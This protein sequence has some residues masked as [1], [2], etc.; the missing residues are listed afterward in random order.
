M[1]KQ[2]ADPAPGARF[3]HVYDQRGEPT[4]DSER[5]RHRVGATIDSR[6][7]VLDRKFKQ[8]IE[9]KIGISAPYTKSWP[10]FVK[11][12]ELKHVLDLV[13]V[14]AEYI[15]GRG[16][17]AG[18]ET[19]ARLWLGEIDSIFREEN[20]HYR[21]EPKGGV[22][23]YIDESFSRSRTA[24][25][26]AI[27]DPRYANVLGEFEKGMAALAQATPD[28]KDSIRGVFAAVEGLFL[29]MF[30]D[31]RRLSAG[32]VSRLQPLIEQIYNGNRRAQETSQKL[33]PS[34]RGW[35]D[36]AHGY[37]HEE[38]KPDAVAQPPLRLAVYIVDCGSAHLRWLAELDAARNK[39]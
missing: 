1:S 33:L 5:M 19:A 39:Q 4:E 36:A 21:I 31:L 17:P 8:F 12:I 37:R 28:G 29:L 30:P 18:G 23:Y 26:T 13:T 14:T 22:R 9:R 38:G 25:I 27:A 7:L 2:V 16:A 10:T 32:D 11:E 3:S 35:I 15:R 24:T 6:D 20:V 34:F